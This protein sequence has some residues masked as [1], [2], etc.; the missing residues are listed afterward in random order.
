MKDSILNIILQHNT[1]NTTLTM[2]ETINLQGWQIQCLGN[3]QLLHEA[4]T[5]FL[6]SHRVPVGVTD[7]V[8]AWITSLPED[9]VLMCGDLTGVEQLTLRLALSRDLKV[10]HTLAQSLPQNTDRLTI[11]EEERAALTEGRVAIV[12]P[13]F[14]T[15]EPKASAMTSAQRNKM[16]VAM[17]AHIVVGFMGQNGNLAQQLLGKKNVTI[18]HTE[19]QQEV[20]EAAP[21]RVA[22][23]ANNMAW[24]IYHQLHNTK[25]PSLEMRQLLMQYLELNSERPSLVHSLILYEVVHQYNDLPD[26]NFTAFLKMWD[27]ET[28]RPEDWRSKK[29]DG[30]WIPSLVERVL[31]RLFKNMPSKFNTP[32]NPNEHFDPQL[33]HQLLDKALSLN[34]KNKKMASRAL[35]LAY[36]EHDRKRV[37][38]LKSWK[39]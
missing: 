21:D 19:G 9:A 24:A 7:D 5:T 14:E 25:L 39:S 22:S 27:I 6:C 3:T 12:A 29:V 8:T 34:P 35:R 15:E 23:Q 37:M 1:L 31:S 38:E 32:V 36:F 18:L 33:A 30:K 28:L 13:L 16:M 10:I 17:A 4:T 26:F 20:A 11:S 2:K